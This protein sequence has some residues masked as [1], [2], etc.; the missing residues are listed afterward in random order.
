MAF[1]GGFGRGW[2]K[3]RGR[4]KAVK[5]PLTENSVIP[6]V[7]SPAP[8]PPPPPP[9]PVAPKVPRLG[10]AIIGR[11]TNWPWKQRPNEAYLADMLES[12]DLRIVRVSQD[13]YAPP[14]PS[15]ECAIFT[16][17]PAS[18]GRLEL[19]R[20][21]HPTVLWATNLVPGYQE[22]GPVL[23][24]A[25]T[26]SVF[27]SA[28]RFNWGIAHHVYLP[29]ACNPKTNDFLP[30]PEIPCAFI[31]SPYS[32]HRRRIVSLVK[33]LGGVALDKMSRWRYGRD[34]S[35]F[36]QTVKVVIGDNA[37]NDIPGYWSSRN[38]IIPG[39]G[40]F[41]LTPRVPGLEL[42]FNLD[43]ELAVYDSEDELESKASRWIDDNFTRESVRQAGYERARQDHT[44][45]SR[46]K[47]FVKILAEKVACFR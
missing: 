12:F 10:I 20:K 22:H 3:D 31:G 29:G 2:S 44:W 41:L 9:E 23:E 25:K 28:D 24:A 4:A 16:S 18:F 27:I 38:Y 37:R 26:A 6:R 11:F 35:A 5:K 43:R 13:R 7:V 40:G 45:E 46:A 33:K 8:F 34:L 42:D 47:S 30:R 19:W 21:T 17:H 39:A 32:E 36:V 15:V 14:V 1:G